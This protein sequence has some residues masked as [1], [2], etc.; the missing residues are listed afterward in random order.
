MF[1]SIDLNYLFI[2]IISMLIA[3][4]FHEA[5]HGL[6]ARLL[7]DD[8]ADDEGRITLNP[9]RHVDIFLTILLPAV[10]ILLSLPPIFAA[11]PVPFD[12]SRVRYGDFGAA[13]VGLAGPFSNLALAVVGA[14]IAR[15]LGVDMQAVSS[16]AL[17]GLQYAL[18]IFIIINIS[19]FVF[20]MLPIPPLDGSRLVYAFAPEPVQRIMAQLESMGLVVVLGIF[21]LLSSYIGPIISTIS[22]AILTFLLR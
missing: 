15:G 17:D 2:V 21:L 16:G 13:L 10:M 18:V 22:E 4:P 12:P 7:G 11:K 6:T 5:M 14:L 1:G 9:F 20:N 19:L 8:T 3:I